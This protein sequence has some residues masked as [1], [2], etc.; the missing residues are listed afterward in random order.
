MTMLY[1][2]I[3]ETILNIKK[4]ENCIILNKWPWFIHKSFNAQFIFL[5]QQGRNNSGNTQ[6]IDFN[7]SHITT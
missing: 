2:I 5:N 4:E 1:S 3:R 6:V 7:I